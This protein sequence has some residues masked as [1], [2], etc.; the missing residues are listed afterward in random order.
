MRD[1]KWV[2][3]LALTSNE[4]SRDFQKQSM[5]NGELLYQAV[6]RTTASWGSAD[7]TMYVLG[8]THPEEVAACRQLYPDHFF[9]IPGIGAQGGDLEAILRA[10]LNAQGGLLI[11]ASR[12]ILYASSGVDFAEKGREEAAHINAAYMQVKI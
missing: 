6:M 1:D 4:G 5:A 8:A 11:N 2:I 9:L 7:N 12:S 10:G 3:L